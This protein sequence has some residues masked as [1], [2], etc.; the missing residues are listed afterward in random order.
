MHC[1][2]VDEICTFPDS[3]HASTGKTPPAL[4]RWRYRAAVVMLALLMAGCNHAI[5]NYPIA[6]EEDIDVCALALDAVT[7]TINEAQVTRPS[8]NVCLFNTPETS[9]V[10]GSIQVVLYTRASMGYSEGLGQVLRNTMAEA[11][12][13]YG[14][15]G[16]NGFAD[17]PEGAVS[18]GFGSNPSETIDEVIVTERGVL[19]AIS[20]S[21]KVIGHDELVALTRGLWMRVTTYDPTKGT[22]EE[23][24]SS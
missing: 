6:S 19:M 22:S 21:G 15:P 10:R 1:S 23:N 9:A 12:Q 3:F 18:V 14:N 20:I 7:T 17:L 4:F 24:E 8:Q 13:T 2:F 16:L 5:G 11:E